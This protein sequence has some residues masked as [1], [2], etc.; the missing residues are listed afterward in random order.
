M[1]LREA[2]CQV[3]ELPEEGIL[4]VEP[5]EGEFS[6]ES[7]TVVLELSDSELAT[8]VASVAALRA[9][10]TEY[11]LEAFLVKEFIESWLL[12]NPGMPAGHPQAIQRIISYAVN[13]A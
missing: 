11:F 1:N 10:G 9:P 5:I 3:H 13:D 2:I 12:A 7:R 4:F 8:P 6:P